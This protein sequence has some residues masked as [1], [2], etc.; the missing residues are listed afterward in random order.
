M[1]EDGEEIQQTLHEV[2]KNVSSCV[3]NKFNLQQDENELRNF[4]SFSRNPN[5]K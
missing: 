3:G 1:M 2:A 5:P 4:S